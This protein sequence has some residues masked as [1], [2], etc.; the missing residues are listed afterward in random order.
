MSVTER[1]THTYPTTSLRSVFGA[2]R[3]AFRTESVS[4]AENHKAEAHALLRSTWT[5]FHAFLA[6]TDGEYTGEI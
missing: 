4:L 3:S 2:R 1:Y 6:F 5:Y